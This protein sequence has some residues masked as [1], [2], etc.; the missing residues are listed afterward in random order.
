MGTEKKAAV[1]RHGGRVLRKR[2][3]DVKSAK[4][5]KRGVRGGGERDTQI[6]PPDLKGV[7]RLPWEVSQGNNL[8]GE[9]RPQVPAVKTD[10]GGRRGNWKTNLNEESREEERR[11]RGGAPMGVTIREIEGS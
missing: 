8:S 4:K 11:T 2:G 7:S 3:R 9:P 10:V 1:K 6:R 5:G